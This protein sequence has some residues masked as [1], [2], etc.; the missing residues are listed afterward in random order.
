[1][2]NKKRPIF[3]ICSILLVLISVVCLF[4]GCKEEEKKDYTT[5]SD[6]ENARFGVIAG[7][8][9]EKITK[10]NFPDAKILHFSTLTDMV[11]ALSKKKI[12]GFILDKLFQTGIS[13]DRKDITYVDHVFGEQEYA[14]MFTKNEKGMGLKKQM[15]EYI[16]KLENS[17]ELG[18]LQNKWFSD[19]KPTEKVDFSG[20]TGENGTLKVAVGSDNKPFIYRMDGEFT[21]YEIELLAMFCREYGYNLDLKEVNFNGT[22][23]G[24]NTGKF[25]IGAFALNITGERSEEVLFSEPT[26]AGDL[27]II[28]N[29]PKNAKTL[30]NIKKGTVGIVTGSIYNEI[31]PE[32]FPDITIK[33]FSS[34]ADIILAMEQG[35]IDA[36]IEDDIFYYGITWD[37]DNIT[38]IEADINTFE[39]A[40]AI[41]K[42][43]DEKIKNN[44]NE[45]IING[46]EDGTLDKLREKWFSGSEPT[47]HPDYEKLPATNGVIN[48][49]L[50]PSFKPNSYK[51]GNRCSGYEVEFLTM[52]AREYGYALNI[53]E[54]TFSS[55][56]TAV[57]TG[58]IDMA[59][60]GISITE[61]RKESMDFSE[62]YYTGKAV[63]IVVD[64][65]EGKTIGEF[66]TGIKE[67]FE[68]TFIREERWKLIL[69]GVLVT[70]LISICAAIGGT[71]VGFA[72]YL[73]SQSDI[74]A[75]RKITRG[76]TRVYSRIISGTP[77][78]V[79]L[80]ILYYIVFGYSRSISGIAVSI[81]GFAIVFGSFVYEHMTV[82]VSSVNAGQ[83]EAAY[84]LGY[85]KNKAFVR[86][87]FPQAAA[88][89]LPS[90]IGQ[91]VELIKATAVVGYIAVND[92]TKMGD[93]IRSNTYEAFFPLIAVA[94]IYF[95]LT[96]LLSFILKQFQK[97]FEPKR[98]EEEEIL[99]GVRIYD[100]N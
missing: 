24:V 14:Y 70:M 44:L 37:K 85:T 77:I 53:K 62:S 13:W 30:E 28:T 99:K 23:T 79:I 38:C 16:L 90:Y 61:E 80:M 75:I 25:D 71:I 72:L 89:F 6:F 91:A 84:A 45:F 42:K 93:I 2:T 33:N 55:I 76:I 27:V 1:M 97:K 22:L 82:S 81:I 46:K 26:V 69:E 3:Q 34:P 98:R 54:M 78:I 39:L 48:I 11:L 40:V 7:A 58:K 8:P 88:V 15:D 18:A 19:E 87:V 74:K 35:K 86:I 66:F 59:A 51:K 49:A 47:E 32:L 92:L 56:I 52:F 29:A 5:V 94:V 10:D 36:Y 64:P 95:F 4:T 41:S 57:A 43:C 31:V 67:S 100:K 83:L 63:L 20:F 12:D 9:T 65:G 17:G 50:D 60:N 73:M 21:G 68:K 96:W